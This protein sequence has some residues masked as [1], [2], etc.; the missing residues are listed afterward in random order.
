MPL[1]HP[2]A[3]SLPTRVLLT[4]NPTIGNSA[5][6]GILI[7]QRIPGRVLTGEYVDYAIEEWDRSHGLEVELEAED[8]DLAF[9][10]FVS[11]AGPKQRARPREEEY[12][13]GDVSATSAKRIKIE[14]TNTSLE[15]A[16]ALWISVRGCHVDENTSAPMSYF[17]EINST[18]DNKT[19]ELDP[20]LDES[21]AAHRDD[22]RCKNCNQWVPQRTM[23]LHENFC[24]R[25]NV[26]CPQC[27]RVFQKS[28]YSWQ[29]H[30]HCPR[31][32]AYGF[33]S[34]QRE[35][36]DAHFHI[37]QTCRDC[38]YE[39]ANMRDLAH[40]RT[41][42]C[43][44][45]LI[46]CQFCH[47][48]VP[49]QGPDDPDPSTPEVILSGLNPHEL[50]DGARTTECHLCAKI[51][52]L[53][54][55]STHLRHH[56]LQRLSRIKP[57]LCRNVNCGRTIDH[58]AKNG[59]VRQQQSPSNDLGICE[60]CF[61]PLYVSM[62]DPDGKALR[63]RVERKYL[64]QLLTGCGQRWCGNEYCRTA[65]AGKGVGDEGKVTSK[66]ALVMVKPLLEGLTRHGG[67]QVYFCTDESSQRRRSLAELIA[68]E[69]GREEFARKGK[70][71]ESESG[72]YEL[73][74]C[75]AAL[76][77]EGGDLDR[78]RQWLKDYAPTRVESAR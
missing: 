63:R 59:E 1:Q 64:T 37:P 78:A 10:L 62:Y 11:P 53:R 33:S 73:E 66:E 7:G 34:S 61:G 28:S 41:T 9:D 65:R 6:G 52:R 47:L 55:M 13:F 44:A 22:V 12:L 57:R 15:D 18:S 69:A 23:I 2:A 24:L 16:E 20:P 76:D 43:P 26:V 75:T 46:L 71:K 17:V 35:H 27:S 4:T 32:A 19:S 54:D 74:W 29:N 48:I 36:H 30:W 40:H 31:D 25:N 39:A 21:T 50:A 51:V 38:N 72:G 58:V 68:A 14:H 5:G 49:Q 3:C 42:T 77:A 60:T 45:K 8:P 70:G 56:D 67:S